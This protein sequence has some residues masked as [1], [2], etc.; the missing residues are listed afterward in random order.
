MPRIQFS[1][2]TRLEWMKL[3][4]QGIILITSE[5]L[6]WLKLI[7]QYIFYPCFRGCLTITICRL[8]ARNIIY[9][10][11]VSWQSF[12]EKWEYILWSNLKRTLGPYEDFSQFLLICH[13]LLWTY[14][15]SCLRRCAFV[16]K[17]SVVEFF[18]VSVR[19]YRQIFIKLGLI[20]CW[21]GVHSASW[22]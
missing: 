6:C 3:E 2:H 10:L 20:S 9:C 17:A 21:N 12:L 16:L 15:L 19:A 13:C 11:C 8:G 18:D 7:W 14:F 4:M 5:N 1:N 22:V